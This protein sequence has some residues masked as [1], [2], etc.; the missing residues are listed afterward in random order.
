MTDLRERMLTELPPPEPGVTMLAPRGKRCS[1]CLCCDADIIFDGE[2]LCGPCDDGTHP[3]LPEVRTPLTNCRCVLPVA[4]DDQPQPAAPAAEPESETEMSERFKSMKGI[5]T[6]D[7]VRKQIE[8][9]GFSLSARLLAQKYGV[10]DATV[11]AIRKEAGLRKSAKTAA[12]PQRKADKKTACK[13]TVRSAQTGK[14]WEPEPEVLT[15]PQ[16]KSVAIKV[17]EPLIDS[18]WKHL[19]F[20]AKAELFAGNYVIRIEGIVS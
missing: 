2:A 9:E 5:R 6:P 19:S 12:H 15:P 7:D 8:N 4:P 16:S 1:R 17:T 10:S 14:D 3:P 13:L 18:W 20:D 11:V